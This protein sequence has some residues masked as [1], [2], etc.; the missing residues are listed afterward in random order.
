MM[1]MLKNKIIFVRMER[2]ARQVEVETGE[3]LEAVSSNN[4]S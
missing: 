1:N 2:I 4:F 3:I